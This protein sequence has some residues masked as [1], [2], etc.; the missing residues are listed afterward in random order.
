MWIRLIEVRIQPDKLDELRKIY[1]EEIVPVVSS[2]K[3][4]IEVLLMES[5]DR[6]G[7][8]ISFTSW[9]SQEDGDAYE[10]SGT[11]VKMVNKVKHTFVGMP[12]LWSYE[13]KK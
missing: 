4:N 12:T 13:V 8:I 2:H 5:Q 7:Q 11:Y 3:G 9:E 1:N 10:G 6:P